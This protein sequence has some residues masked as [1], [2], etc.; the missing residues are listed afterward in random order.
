MTYKKPRRIFEGSGVVNPEES[1]YVPL[2]N[3][4]SGDRPEFSCPGRGKKEEE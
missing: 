2:E 3:E 1:Y 4:R